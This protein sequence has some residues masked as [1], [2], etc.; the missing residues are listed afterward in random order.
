MWS[1]KAIEEYIINEIQENLNLEY[2]SAKAVSREDKAVVEIS[3]DISAMANSQGGTIIYGVKEFDEKVKR[4]LPEKID[5]VDQTVFTKEWL[6]QIIVSNIRPKVQGLVIYPIPIEP[7]PNDIVFVV[8][9]QQSNTAHQ[10]KDLRYYKRFNF[11]CVPMEDYEIRDI[12]NRAN[13]PNVSIRFGV[14]D[15]VFE[16]GENKFVSY[17]GLRVII[18]NEGRQVINKLKL[19]MAITNIGSYDDFDELV[20][21]SMVNFGN[22][23]KNKDIKITKRG[24]LNG[25]VDLVVVYQTEYVVFPQ[26]EIDVAEKLGWGFEEDIETG[27]LGK[28]KDF[29]RD[30]GWEIKWK[31]FADNMPFIEGT[32][33]VFELPTM[34][35]YTS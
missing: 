5:P 35:P 19:S 2:K 24:N 30:A 6:E 15:G 16:A 29:A 21:N 33:K 13:V 3:K 18:R 32:E 4:H 14:Y 26:E 11:Q 23:S 8:E 7:N 1:Q 34:P 27:V 25:S 17:R 31:L 22:E 12:M 28:W 9:I 10:A 20:N